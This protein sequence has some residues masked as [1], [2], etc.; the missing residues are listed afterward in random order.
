MFRPWQAILAPVACCL[1]LTLTG[2][3]SGTADTSQ[4]V[5]ASP[6]PSGLIVFMTHVVLRPQHPAHVTFHIASGGLRI[7]VAAEHPLLGHALERLTRGPSL[8]VSKGV[9][10]LVGKGHTAGGQTGY[11]LRNAKPLAPGWYRLELICRGEVIQLS[12]EGR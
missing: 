12:I 10:A 7:H 9:V 4:P 1:L 8:P 2:C 11:V 5:S 6:A 3:A